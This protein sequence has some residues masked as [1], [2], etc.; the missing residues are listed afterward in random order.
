M[1]QMLSTNELIQHMRSKGIRFNIVSDIEASAFLT[2]NNYYFKLAL[3]Y[4]YDQLMPYSSKRKRYTELAAF[5]NG[6]V[7]EHANYFKTNQQII[8]E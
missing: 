8:T 4:V 7:N 1:K 2:H 5:M 3:L 6:R